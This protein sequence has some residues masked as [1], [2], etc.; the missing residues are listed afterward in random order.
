MRP[1]LVIGIT[2]GIGSGKT[3]VANMFADLGVAVIDADEVAR[4]VVARGEPAHQEI[5][6]AFGREILDP[7]GEIDRA[8]MRDRV[9]SDPVKRERLEAIVHPRVYAELEKRLD[10]AAGPYAIVV[11][12]LLIETGGGGL[13]DRVLVVDT[14]EELQIE[15][16]RRRDGA[17]R[18]AVEKI[19]AAQ[20]DRRSRLAAADDIIENAASETALR[21]AVSV[22]HQKYLGA[23]SRVASGQAG[24]KE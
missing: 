6:E 17:T 24:M 21:D 23:S 9:F 22:L 2:G 14:P 19:L 5:V 16:T 3:T 8:R 1:S 12:P 10:R 7:S 13:V 20:I 18:E 15:R 11:V 4:A